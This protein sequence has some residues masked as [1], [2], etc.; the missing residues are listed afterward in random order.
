KHN[1]EA[2]KPCLK[3]QGCTYLWKTIGNFSLC[4][5]L[6]ITFVVAFQKLKA[7]YLVPVVSVKPLLL[8]DGLTDS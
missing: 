1:K 6:L 7:N 2:G 8:S 3:K 5:Y 4:F